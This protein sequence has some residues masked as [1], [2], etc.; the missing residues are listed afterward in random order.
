MLD[1][2][3]LVLMI[4]VL[5]NAIRGNF[6]ETPCNVAIVIGFLAA[7]IGVIT[8]FLSTGSSSGAAFFLNILCAVIAGL[9]KPAAKHFVKLYNNK[10]AEEQE[11]LS[12]ELERMDRFNNKPPV[13]TEENFDDPNLR[14]NGEYKNVKHK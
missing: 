14:F 5:V 1:L 3:F 11:R 2:V 4:I 9:L 13:Y 7:I 10:L 6:L 12:R 8:A